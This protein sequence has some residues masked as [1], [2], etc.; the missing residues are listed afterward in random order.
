MKLP[1]NVFASAEK[2]IQLRAF[3][4]PSTWIEEMKRISDMIIMPMVVLCLYLTGEGDIFFAAS[5]MATAIT[6]WQR[7][8]DYLDLHFTMQTMRIKM[9]LV[10]GPKIVTNDPKYMPYVWA[11]S[12]S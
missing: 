1:K 7:W 8:F 9:A 10:G 3:F 4:Y 11:H 12:I 6:A 2:Y 5:T